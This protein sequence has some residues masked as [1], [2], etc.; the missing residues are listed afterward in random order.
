MNSRVPLPPTPHGFSRIRCDA[1]LAHAPREHGAQK[2]DRLAGRPLAA[3]DARLAAGA[4]L[5]DRG[6]PANPDR[7]E[8]AFDPARRQRVDVRPAKQRP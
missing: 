3:R 7:G 6:R 4:G 2:M 8:G 5:H 1:P